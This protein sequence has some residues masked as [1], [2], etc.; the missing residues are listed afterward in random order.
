MENDRER[1]PGCRTR[2]GPWTRR[3]GLPS[4]SLSSVTT[5]SS[6]GAG[7]LGIT[8]KAA[9]GGSTIARS[10]RTGSGPVAPTPRSS[11]T[12][13]ASHRGG[14]S[15]AVP[16]N[17]LA[18][19]T[20]AS[21]TRTRR[22]VRTGGLPASTSTRNIAARASHVRRCEA[23]STRSPMPPAAGGRRFHD[24]RHCYATWLVSGK[25][26]VNVVQAVMGHEQA[27]TT[28]NRYT[29]PRPPSTGRCERSSA[30]PLTI[31]EKDDR[32]SEEE[33]ESTD[34]P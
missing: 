25:V 11:S 9:R 30:A 16:R 19:S 23:P 17:F 34:S 32:Q 10:R 13:T 2:S 14:A 3:R 22:R 26:P 21:T 20:G 6:A 8:R 15:T 27:S 5:G 24:L 1:T 31:T 4:R 12:R 29:H 33:S 7:A 28:L 18:S